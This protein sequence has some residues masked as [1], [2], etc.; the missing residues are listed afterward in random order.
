LSTRATRREIIHTQD[1]K[2][3]YTLYAGKRHLTDKVIPRLSPD[4]Q[5]SCSALSTI[6]PQ[7]HTQAVL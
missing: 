7:I 4:G 3:M 2:F 1:R 5:H 6:A